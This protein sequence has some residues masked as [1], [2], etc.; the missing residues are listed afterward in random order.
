MYD[1]LYNQDAFGDLEGDGPQTLAAWP[2]ATRIRA[3]FRSYDIA[4]IVPNPIK[5]MQSPSV[6][7]VLPSS[8][9][10]NRSGGV[11]MQVYL[12][13][14]GSLTDTTRFYPVHLRQNVPQSR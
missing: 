10:I 1:F 14:C 9:N 8:R 3:W 6:V 4:A 12:H 7:L 5:A 11:K 13:L 2:D